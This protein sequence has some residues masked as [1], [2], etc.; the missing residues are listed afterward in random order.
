MCH[1]DECQHE[2]AETWAEGQEDSTGG[3]KIVPSHGDV[4]RETGK[5][6]CSAEIS[7]HTRKDAARSGRGRVRI[8]VERGRNLV[9]RQ[10]MLADERDDLAERVLSGAHRESPVTHPTNS[11]VP[12]GTLLDARGNLMPELPLRKR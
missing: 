10:S 9:D 5:H 8:A 3:S 4:D 12:Y 2:R 6:E 1:A 7:K 11:T